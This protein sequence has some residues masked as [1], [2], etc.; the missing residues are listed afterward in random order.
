M[1][2]IRM[3]CWKAKTLSKIQIVQSEES[4]LEDSSSNLK[5]HLHIMSLM[6][7]KSTEMDQ[8]CDGVNWA[9]DIDIPSHSASSSSGC[10]TSDLAP[11]SSAREGQQMISQHLGTSTFPHGRLRWS[12]MNKPRSL[13]PFGNEPAFKRF[14]HV[15]PS[16]CVFVSICPSNNKIFF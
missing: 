3:T 15:F 8:C 13:W 4:I 6:D 2:M 7:L 11:C 14:L 12:S 10:S 9:C 1:S 5:E 16:V